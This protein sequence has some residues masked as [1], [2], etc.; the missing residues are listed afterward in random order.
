VAVGFVVLAAAN[1]AWIAWALLGAN[2]QAGR[3]QVHDVHGSVAY[4]DGGVVPVEM[5]LVKMFPEVSRGAV[6]NTSMPLTARVDP[7]TGHFQGKWACS[8][9]ERKRPAESWR[10]IVLSGDQQPLAEGVVPREYGVVEETPLIVSMDGSPL[11]IRIRRPPA[12]K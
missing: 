4:V 3:F 9:K 7:T 6:S 12:A 5:M 10:V 1:V 2:A 8:Q 11:Q